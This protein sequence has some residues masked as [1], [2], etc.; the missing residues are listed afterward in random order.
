MG[1]EGGLA[2]GAHGRGGVNVTD[3]EIRAAANR[4]EN[5]ANNCTLGST[6]TNR[7]RDR[8]LLEI[9]SGMFRSCNPTL[10]WPSLYFLEF[11]AHR[12]VMDSQVRGDLLQPIPMLSVRLGDP[13]FPI[14]RKD[15]LQCRFDWF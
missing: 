9:S 15:S 8:S 13:L 1:I 11:S 4:K 2:L 5:W 3:D 10:L 6:S 12:C 7:T 14:L